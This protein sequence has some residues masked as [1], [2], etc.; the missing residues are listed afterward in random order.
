MQITIQLEN[1]V[2]DP[3]IVKHYDMPDDHSIEQAEDF[4]GDL[5]KNFKSHEIVR[6]EVVYKPGTIFDGINSDDPVNHRYLQSALITVKE[7]SL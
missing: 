5:L 3:T 2:A 7:S 1:G 4:V 6:M